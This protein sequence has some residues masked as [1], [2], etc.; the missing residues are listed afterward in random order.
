MQLN[1][2]KI[3]NGLCALL[4]QKVI[5][6]KLWGKKERKKK[7]DAKISKSVYHEDHE[8]DERYEYDKSEGIYV[9]KKDVTDDTIEPNEEDERR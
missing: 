9:L 5:R 1:F 4:K 6:K 8:N 3:N 7:K 2:L